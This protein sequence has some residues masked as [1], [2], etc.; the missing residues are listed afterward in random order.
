MAY[1]TDFTNAQDPGLLR[2]IQEA[3]C[4]VALDVQAEATT[5]TFHQA[6]S[7]Y[8]LLVLANPSGYA[9]FMAYTI[10]TDG[11]V[12]PASIDSVVKARVSSVWN[13]FA[14]QT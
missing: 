11:N 10:C 8:A 5:T 4:S 14:C 13:A 6:R 2:V 7:A 3:M 12:T 9:S 1:S